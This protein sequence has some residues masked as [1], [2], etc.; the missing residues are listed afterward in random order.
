[1]KVGLIIIG[2]LTAVAGLVGG[3][4]ADPEGDSLAATA[5][6]DE[7]L[8]A[9][10]QRTP[11]KQTARSEA[12]PVEKFEF[13]YPSGALLEVHFNGTPSEE[14]LSQVGPH[15]A[16]VSTTPGQVTSGPL[17]KK[18]VGVYQLAPP[19]SVPQALSQ[20]LYWRNREIADARAMSRYSRRP[21]DAAEHI[22]N[23]RARVSALPWIVEEP[24]T[25]LLRRL[26]YGVAAAASTLAVVVLIP[27]VMGMIWR[28][29]LNRIR[30]LSNAFRGR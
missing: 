30:E 21:D 6:F 29:L 16:A 10:F 8:A 28:F 18:I 9:V 24:N 13:S 1:M 27:L 19:W 7:R 15:M 3:F 5:A 4:L 23:D 14:E 22:W 20:G 2:L 25:L 17:A 11:L 26:V 12:A